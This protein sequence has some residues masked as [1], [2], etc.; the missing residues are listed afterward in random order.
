MPRGRRLD[1]T[2]FR[3]GSLTIISRAETINGEAFWHFKCDCGSAGTVRST[4]IARGKR[5]CGCK[6]RRSPCA[7]HDFSGEILGLLTVVRRIDPEI[8]RPIKWECRCQCG[9]VKAFTS[10]SLGLGRQSCG[11]Q[12]YH[13]SR[14]KTHGHSKRRPEYK[15]WEAMKHRCYNESNKKYHRYGGRGVYVCDR[16][17]NGY[18]DFAAD[19]GIRPSQLHSIDRID[20]DGS[21]TCG[22]HDLCDDCREKNAPANCRWATDREQCT[23]TMRNVYLTANGKTQSLEEWAAELSVTRGCLYNRRWRGWSD[24]EIID[25]KL[26]HRGN[27]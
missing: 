14:G 23:N 6:K 1:F 24:E 22:K 7:E 9:T 19:M 25:P 13:R 5:S 15:A 4:A 11:C 17:R 3:Q 21:Y 2:D 10:F 18:A 16:W 20:N 12:P 27:V 26:R 8:S